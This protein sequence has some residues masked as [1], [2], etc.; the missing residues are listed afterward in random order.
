MPKALGAKI[1]AFKAMHME[2]MLWQL[3]NTTGQE[4]ADFFSL[5][6]TLLPLAMVTV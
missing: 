4:T 3:R 5:A 6:K 1:G 2:K